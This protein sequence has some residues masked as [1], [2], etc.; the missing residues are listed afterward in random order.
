MVRIQSDLGMDEDALRRLSATQHGTFSLAQL[1]A[2]GTTDSTINQ[3]LSSGRWTREL[4]R[5][6]G[7]AGHRE[8]W[9]RSLWAAYLNAGDDAVLATN[10]AGRIQGAEEAYAGRVE[11]LVRGARGKPPPGI[12]WRR[13][14]DL[15]DDDIV[16]IEGLPPMTSPARTAVDM[17][18]LLSVTRLR[19]FVESGVVERRFTLA[20]VGAVLGRIRRSGKPG[21][22]RMSDVLDDLGPGERMARSELERMGD[23]LIDLAGLPAPIH[24]HPLPNERGRAGFVDRFWPRAKWIVEFDGRSW[25]D[26]RQQ[27][28]ADADRR[29]EAEA[30]GYQTSQILWEHAVGDADRTVE[31][32]RSIHRSRLELHSHSPSP[33]S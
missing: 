29:L 15:A 8:S 12:V 17:A 32:L 11:L 33:F 1:R 2:L 23:R 13:T 27:R 31:L 25:H 21:V 18:A 28:L 7:L 19:R 14:V 9:H 22:R 20:E 30:L 4:P 3:R 6:Y 5:V 26:R 24:E 16:T 10:T